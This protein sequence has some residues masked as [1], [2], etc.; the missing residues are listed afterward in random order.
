MSRASLSQTETQAETVETMTEAEKA[1]VPETAVA[2]MV[3][4]W[5]RE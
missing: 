4:G 2:Q 5:Q 3:P 1:M